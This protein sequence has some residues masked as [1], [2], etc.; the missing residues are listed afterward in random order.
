MSTVYNA[1]DSYDGEN[2]CVVF[3]ERG[4]M[5]GDVHGGMQ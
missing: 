1:Q 3:G 5:Q 4:K 2:Y